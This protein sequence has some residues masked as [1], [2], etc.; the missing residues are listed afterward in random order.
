MYVSVSG[1]KVLERWRSQDDSMTIGGTVTVSSA[2]TVTL[3]RI[4]DGNR[5][6]I[7]KLALEPKHDKG[8]QLNKLTNV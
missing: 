6:I 1:A 7:V 8:K 3:L 5:K 2:R 4:V